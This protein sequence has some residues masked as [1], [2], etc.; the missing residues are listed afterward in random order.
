MRKIFL[1]AIFAFFAAGAC[2]WAQSAKVVDVKGEVTVKLTV[3]SDW[4][5]AKIHM[6]LE[7][8]A[9][10]QTQKSS[11]CTLAFD[12]EFKNI[13]TVKEDSHIKI[14]NVYPG[15][16]FLPQG[17]VFTLIGSMPKG[18][19]FQVRTPTAVSGARGT[20]WLTSFI[21]GRTDAR[22]FDHKIFLQCVVDDMVEE[23]SGKELDQG[24][25]A[26]IG[27]DCAV[28][29]TFP[30]DEGDWREWED[31]KENIGVIRGD[32]TIPGEE[33]DA[34]RDAKDDRNDGIADAQGER[35]RKA[36][37]DSPGDEYDD[38]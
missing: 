13:L 9:E 29:D 7:R 33:D 19:E 24:Y 23:K 6:L 22:V 28:G 26:E 34:F 25:G 10:V 27:E 15:T 17:R 31:F 5:K 2:A 12:E 21:N 1:S 11:Q 36:A 30:L 35:Q 4:Q 32:I 37:E 8:E 18:E 16:V 38:F 20:G 14:Q 3:V